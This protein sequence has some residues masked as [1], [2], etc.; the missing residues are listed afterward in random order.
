VKWK[1]D[2]Y[3]GLRSLLWRR[4]VDEDVLEEFEHHIAERT[5]AN[6]ARGMT[7]S[8]AREE[9][10]RRFGDV[11]RAARETIEI[12]ES[13][14]R[15]QKR[16]E[17]F[18]ALKRELT[19][20]VRSLVRAPVFTVVAVVTLALGIGASTAVYTLLK[21]VVLDPLRYPASERLITID[22][23]TPGISAGS[24]WGMS[25]ASY[26]HFKERAR[27]LDDLGIYA[28]N[29]AHLR[30]TSE[31]TRGIAVQVSGN[32][33]SMLGAR[34]VLGRLIEVADDDPGAPRVV[35]LGHEFWQTHFGGDPNVVGGTLGVNGTP[36]EIVGVLD[37]GFKLP[38]Q[39]ADVLYAR[40][41]HP[42]MN[43]VNWHY[44]FGIGRL[45]AGVSLDAARAELAQLTSELD[46]AY[47]SVYGSGFME[48]TK[49]AT[50][51]RD[52]RESI[53]GELAN[54]LWIL[55][56]SV[57]VVLVIA[58]VNVANLFLVRSESR[59]TEDAIRSALGARRGHVFVQSVSESLLIA[60]AA[61]AIGVWLADG[62]LRLLV[63]MAP[64][65]L[66]RVDEIGLSTETVFFGFAIAA[67]AGL[68][69]A[70]FRFLHGHT[71]YAPLREGGR[72]LTASR[73]RLR[74]RSV[75]VTAQ[76]ALA[77]ILLASAGLMLRSFRAMHRVDLGLDPENVLTFPVYLPV[78][79]YD[80][81]EKATRFWRELSDR[82]A[83][84]PGVA[85][86]G[87]T[88][89]PPLIG[90]G[91]AIMTVTPPTRGTDRLDC[92][93][94]MIITPGWF[95]AMGIPVS[96]RAPTWADIDNQTGAVVISR[97]LADRLWPG[98][99]PIGRGLKV[100]TGDGPYYTIIGVAGDIRAGGVREPPTQLVYYPL[101]ELEGS[102]LWGPVTSLSIMIRTTGVEPDQLVPVVRTAIASI[103]RGAAIG[104][105]SSFEDIVARSMIRTTFTTVLL[106]IAGVMALVLS[107]V[108]M[109]GVIAY[110]VSRRRSEIGI[111][112]ALGAR[113]D[114][115]ARM[116][117]LQSL[118]LGAIGVTIGLVATAFTTNLLRSLL[119]GV[120]PTDPLTLVAVAFSLL[121]VAGLA[122]FIPAARAATVQP[123]ETLRT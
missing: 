24:V 108:G 7:P 92:V 28:V 11:M 112:M 61:G 63:A 101:R 14:V 40:R 107:I 54:T 66:A 57:G 81:Y 41:L 62:G 48:G 6:V 43:H 87:G 118:R 12:D 120:E 23:E 31:A 119:F 8:A 5:A 64:S 115:I 45:K 20:S 104:S 79:E 113:A 90:S 75:L 42:T 16:M 55:L 71:D 103:D 74:A 77:V 29:Q 15:E 68:V 100:P 18:D 10:L 94:N 83:A 9:A 82:I 49:F 86:V 26:F 84:I 3:G 85:S 110:T 17:L 117:L 67:I 19:H 59:R 109:Y 22:H 69:F 122:S 80:T 36:M 47:P 78:S 121:V 46:E 65:G 116:F 76:V 4:S 35:V 99:D 32:L 89:S 95:D 34:A 105:V 114:E 102:P 50:R 27:T 39:D 30:T 70:L 25:S 52:L 37:G 72:G 33:L 96:G 13:I 44:L 53:V 93:P 2:R 38:E 56:G 58:C 98:E 51:V 106:G 123:T 60:L 111:R 21:T 88:S 73:A 91:C 1:P 97:A